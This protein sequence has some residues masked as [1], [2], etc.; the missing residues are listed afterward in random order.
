MGRKKNY[1]DLSELSSGEKVW[2]IIIAILALIGFI[3]KHS[4]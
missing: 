2:F 4:R 1:K 3:I